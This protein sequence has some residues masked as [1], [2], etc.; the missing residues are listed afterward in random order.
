MCICIPTYTMASGMMTLLM[1]PWYIWDNAWTVGLVAAMIVYWALM[2][3]DGSLLSE[4]EYG[5]ITNKT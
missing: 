1:Q 2:H 4:A 5:T 3:R